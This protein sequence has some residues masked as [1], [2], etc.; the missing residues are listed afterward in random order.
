[1][2]VQAWKTKQEPGFLPFCVPNLALCDLSSMQLLPASLATSPRCVAVGLLL[3][4]GECGTQLSKQPTTLAERVSSQ[5][6][7][8][9]PRL[10]GNLPSRGE[11]R[12]RQSRSREPS[13]SGGLA[14]H[15]RGRRR[16]RQGSVAEEHRPKQELQTSLVQ[17]IEQPGS[18]CDLAFVQAGPAPAAAGSPA[19]GGRSVACLRSVGAPRRQ[20]RTVCSGPSALPPPPLPGVAPPACRARGELGGSL[21]SPQSQACQG[22]RSDGLF[23]RHIR[24][25]WPLS[26]L[27]RHLLRAWDREAVGSPRSGLT[28]TWRCGT[29]SWRPTS[30]SRRA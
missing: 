4:S 17:L 20:G 11:P 14:L 29:S 19:F 5:A 12:S 13:A 1:M 22:S 7:A 10:P 25:R 2:D 27:T 9:P 26:L 18:L 30:Q 24:L 23:A 16:R 6:T 8:E 3:F 15:S 21:S 28:S